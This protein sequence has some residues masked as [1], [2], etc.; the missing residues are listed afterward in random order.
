LGSTIE[1]RLTARSAAETTVGRTSIGL[2]S[3]RTEIEVGVGL[4]ALI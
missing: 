2:A 3:G 1:V 4:P